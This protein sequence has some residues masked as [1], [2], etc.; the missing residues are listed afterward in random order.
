MQ[1]ND[2]KNQTEE[3]ELPMEVNEI[4]GLKKAKRRKF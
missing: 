2:F 3:E 4:P 1:E